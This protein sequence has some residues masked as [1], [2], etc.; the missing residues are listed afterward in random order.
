MSAA[1]NCTRGTRLFRGKCRDAIYTRDSD[2]YSGKRF[3]KILLPVQVGSTA[4]EF[5]EVDVLVA[6]S[7]DRRLNWNERS[8]KD[9]A[10]LFLDADGN[11]SPA[12]D[13]VA[14]GSTH[15]GFHS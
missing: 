5:G 10:D 3:T 13:G 15:S 12:P 7:D 8:G 9:D 1:A 4:G 14:V 2:V 6:E 11:I